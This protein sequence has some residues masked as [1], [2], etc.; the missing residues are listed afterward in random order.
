MN[1]DTY[2]YESYTNVSIE[3]SR[4]IHYIGKLFLTFSES[5]KPH[6]DQTS[7][8]IYA[9]GFQQLNK[10]KL[11]ANIKIMRSAMLSW[12]SEK[13]EREVKNGKRQLFRWWDKTIPFINAHPNRFLLSNGKHP[14][15][16]SRSCDL[17][18]SRKPAFCHDELI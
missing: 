11:V 17:A 10:P 8:D 1:Y 13:R 7:P 9:L 12:L 3:V 4:H 5:E 15:A 2:N 6:S 16:H 14:L 18:T